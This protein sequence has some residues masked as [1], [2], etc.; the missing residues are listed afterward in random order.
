MVD[1]LFVFLMTKP[2]QFNDGPNHVR[3]TW[4]VDRAPANFESEVKNHKQ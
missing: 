4:Y 3:S 1:V 2:K